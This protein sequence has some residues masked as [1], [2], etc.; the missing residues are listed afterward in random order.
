MEETVQNSV[1]S[2][3]QEPD[4][5]AYISISEYANKYECSKVAVYEAIKAKRIQWDTAKV[6]GNVDLL[7]SL[8]CS[9]F[10]YGVYFALTWLNLPAELSGLIGGF[11]GFKGTNVISQWI[12]KKLGFDD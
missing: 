9:L 6:N 3:P 8:M 5:T 12:S 11:L 2:V 1:P 7:E 10:S 4:K